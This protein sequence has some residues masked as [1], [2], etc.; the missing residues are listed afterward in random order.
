MIN[1]PEIKLRFGQLDDSF[2]KILS[3][4]P[5]SFHFD[6]GATESYIS[7]EKLIELGIITDSKFMFPIVSMMSGEKFMFHVIK[8]KASIIDNNGNSSDIKEIKINAIID[9]NKSP[10]TKYYNRIGLIGRNILDGFKPYSIIID[11]EGNTSFSNDKSEI[12]QEDWRSFEIEVAN[13]FRLKGL[14]V[15]RNYSLQGNQVDVFLEEKTHSGKMLRT[16]VECKFYNKSVGVKEVRELNY[17]FSFAQNAKLA[18]HAI[19][20]SYSGFSKDAYLVA[21]QSNIELLELEDL[22][23]QVNY[24]ENDFKNVKSNEYQKEVEHINDE[25]EKQAFVIM[26][27]KNEFI[28]IYQLGIRDILNQFDFNC[29]RA[30]ELEFDSLIITKIRELIVTSKIIIAEVTEHNPNVYYELGMAHAFEKNVILCTRKINN[31]PFDISRY[32]HIVYD[33]IVDLRKKL[34]QRLKSIITLHNKV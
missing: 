27:F 1:Y 8:V 26:P 31:S 33:S 14:N 23:Q 18:D 21:E 4:N 28:D 17:L 32:N 9:F 2:E 6:T 22:K 7:F 20:V 29:F 34:S 3:Q 25:N 5:L 12:I 24:K 19:L 15:K 30:D 16:I 10:F 11:S 13:L